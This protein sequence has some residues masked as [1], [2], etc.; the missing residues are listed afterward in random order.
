V[1][2]AAI[3]RIIKLSIAGVVAGVEGII[4]RDVVICIIAT[5]IAGGLLRFALLATG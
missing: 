3:E 1:S 2:P 5:V 4:N